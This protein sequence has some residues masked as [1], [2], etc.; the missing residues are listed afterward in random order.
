MSAPNF[1]K[2]IDFN[3]RQYDENTVRIEKFAIDANHKK[4]HVPLLKE[5]NFL[6]YQNFI[7]R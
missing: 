7:C 3:K 2:I 4:P 6:S 5:R 1:V